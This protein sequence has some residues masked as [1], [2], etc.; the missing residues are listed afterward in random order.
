MRYYQ[1]QDTFIGGIPDGTEHLVTKGE[2]R[3]E[4]DEL[5]KRDLAASRDNPDRVPLFRLLDP[6][7]EVPKAKPAARRAA[8]SDG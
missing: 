1:A 4:T 3:P 8:K 6:G 2:A 7:S 5:V